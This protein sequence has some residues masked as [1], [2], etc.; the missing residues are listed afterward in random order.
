MAFEADFNL[1]VTNCLAYNR[2][3]TMFY[4]A[5]VRMREQGGVVIEQ[6]KKDYPDIDQLTVASDLFKDEFINNRQNVKEISQPKLESDQEYVGP[7]QPVVKQRKKD[8]S[9][10]N[11][12]DSESRLRYI[13]FA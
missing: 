11:R 9:S 12:N 10:R 8:R 3:D 7:E 13:I 5:G 4:R 1:M 6:A 2:K